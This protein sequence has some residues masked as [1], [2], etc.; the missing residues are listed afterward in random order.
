MERALRCA[1]DPRVE[2]PSNWVVTRFHH[3]IPDDD[4]FLATCRFKW[5][6]RAKPDLVIHTTRDH[7]LVIEAKVESG[8]GSYPASAAEKKIFDE[9][10]L[11]RVSQTGLQDHMMRELLGID[12]RHVFLTVH[13]RGGQL[14]WSEAFGA[15]DLSGLPEWARTWIAR[16]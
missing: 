2:S 4:A 11:G 8:E 12:A 10:S 1:V 7:A 14:R 5:C 3:T 13:G 9:R 16:Y 15:L 6:F